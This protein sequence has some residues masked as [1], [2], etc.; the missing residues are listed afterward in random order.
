[1][2]NLNHAMMTGN[3]GRDPE[4]R[5]VGDNSTPLVTFSLACKNWRK[6]EPDWIDCK[7][8]GK[9]AEIMA[10]HLG[11]GDKIAVVG[12]L[13]QERWMTEGGDN[14]SKIV[15]VVESFDFAGGG[16]STG[17]NRPASRTQRKQPAP[18][19]G[20]PVAADDIPF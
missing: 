7:A 16:A 15:L 13:E 17:G 14:R 3:L 5:H 11:K 1:M 9:T 19:Y 20:E 12:R 10:Q 6:D 2:S 4:L 18:D 8:W